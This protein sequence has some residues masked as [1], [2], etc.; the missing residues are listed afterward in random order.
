MAVESASGLLAWKY[1][2]TGPPTTRLTLISFGVCIVCHSARLME[3]TMVFWR[4]SWSPAWFTCHF[5]WHRCEGGDFTAEIEWVNSLV[6][7]GRGVDPFARKTFLLRKAWSKNLSPKLPE[8]RSCCERHE[9][10]V[11]LPSY[12]HAFANPQEGLKGP[13]EE[14]MLHVG[15]HCGEVIEEEFLVSWRNQTFSMVWFWIAWMLV[16]LRFFC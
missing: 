7:A 4:Q 16:P 15:Y 12:P 5:C 6:S 11:C 8:R 2:S 9:A 1:Q 3:W 13:D 14:E 10:K